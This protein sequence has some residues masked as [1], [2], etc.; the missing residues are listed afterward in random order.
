MQIPLTISSVFV[1]LLIRRNC[2]WIFIFCRDFLTYRII[3]LMNSQQNHLPFYRSCKWWQWYPSKVSSE[4]TKSNVAQFSPK[5]KYLPWIMMGCS[6]KYIHTFST[7]LISV[8]LTTMTTHLEISIYLHTFLENF[9][10]LSPPP[11]WNP[12]SLPEG[13]GG[14]G[15]IWIL[16]GTTH[17]VIMCV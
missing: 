8:T 17:F 11:S 13:G 12:P 7:E 1:G 15:V 5:S 16:F 14:G 10:S 4:E 6:R 3:Y 2:A 9:H